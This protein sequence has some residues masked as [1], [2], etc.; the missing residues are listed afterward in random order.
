M[1]TDFAFGAPDRER[2]AAAL[3]PGQLVVA[4][5]HDE[6]RAKL[7]RHPAAEV[8]CTFRPPMELSAL[9]PGVRWVQLPSA[10]ADGAVR[11]GLV[12]PG[13]PVIVT[14]ANGIHAIPIAEYVFSSMLVFVRRWP[15]LLALQRERTWPD[16]S[17][18]RR[19][20]QLRLGGQE[21]YGATLGIVGLGHIGRRVAYLGHAYGMRVLG[22]RRSARVGETDADV[23]ELFPPD[24]LRELLAASDFVVLA[25]PR[26]AQ[27]HHLIGEP[28]L[29]AMRPS[30][31]LVNIA[32]GDV[33]DEAALVRAVKEGWI[34]GAGLDVT[35]HEP[36]DP[37]SPLWTLP[38]VNLSPHVSG[39]TDRYSSRFTDL[40]LENLGRFRAGLTL[41]NTVDPV[42]GY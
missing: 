26:T 2:L 14:T 27:T 17:T 41:L 4:P 24:R 16:S 6:L 35:E 7:R 39:S 36:L 1:I 19:D 3:A 12:A 10:G 11:A 15:T 40:F 32:R 31:Y 33:V 5:D 37:A 28:E 42:R 8:L 38:T 20:P 30:A 22:L 18:R 25:V 29:R 23:E 21:L 9:A 34:A 13:M